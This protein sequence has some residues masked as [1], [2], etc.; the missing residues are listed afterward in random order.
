MRLF[1]A[2]R[3]A[4]L[5]LK[6]ALLEQAYELKRL[7][8]ADLCNR[9]SDYRLSIALTRR[10]IADCDGRHQ[11]SLQLVRPLPSRNDVH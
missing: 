5:R 1:L 3:R 11:P 7:E 8:F 4:R 9:L 10:A 6:L 2:M